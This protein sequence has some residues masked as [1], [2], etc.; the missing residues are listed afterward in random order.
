MARSKSRSG[1]IDF[2]QKNHYSSVFSRTLSA[3]KLCRGGDLVSQIDSNALKSADKKSSKN[4]S[5]RDM[6]MEKRKGELEEELH[7]TREKLGVVEVERD[8]AI[9]EL[10]EAKEEAHEASIRGSEARKVKELTM[11]LKSL[12][13]ILTNSQEELKVKDD[14]IKQFELTLVE[15]D[16]SL[17]QLKEELR[18]VR[19]SNKQATELLSEGEKK[20][21][22]LEAQVDRGKQS[23]SKIIDSLEIKSKQLEQKKIELEE[24]KLEITSLHEKIELLQD[25][26]KQNSRD[27]KG[28]S[29]KDNGDFSEEDNEWLKS[30]LQLT[31]ENL[32]RA[33]E[34]E[35]KASLKVK[36]LLDEMELFKN[37]LTM[38]IDAEEKSA[39]AM[40]DLALALKEVTTEANQTKEKLDNAQLELEQVKGEVE[41]LKAM[42]RSTDERHQKLLDEAKQEAELYKN[43]ADRLRLEAEDSIL[44]SNGKEMGFVSCIKRA[45][46]EAA[47]AQRESARLAESLKTA[48]DMTR[49]AREETN[50]L[51]DILKQAINEANAA[52]A[53]ADIA[54]DENSQLKD[55]LSERDDSLNFISQ[56]HESLGTNLKIEDKEK[57]GTLKSS[58]SLEDNNSKKHFSFNLQDLKFT[59]E[60]EKSDE[61]LLDEDPKKAETLKGSIFDSSAETPRSEL[62]TPKSSVSTHRR[63][64]SSAFTDDT[65]TPNSVDFDHLDN[66]QDG[67]DRERNIHR[68]RKTMFWRV[69]DLLMIGRS[70]HKKE[71]STES[72]PATPP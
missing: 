65:G 43:T 59:N 37:E 1:S 30:E 17:D 61:K 2:G 51:R 31:K 9:D 64:Y 15:R 21:Q 12:K 45:E 60:Y 35:K 3:S 36:S 53:A 33:Q 22:E 57:N 28:L 32:A 48:E 10:K 47:V 23:E 52:K 6:S 16:A 70:F 34:D 71:P 40:E 8:Q 4:R 19:E 62:H 50:K 24:S 56:E 54:R 20:I 63:G 44:A 39:K 18:S 26:S 42:V 38:A 67:S 5:N 68:R 7:R 25:S 27:L 41:K 49:A 29:N 72:T 46:E 55:C 11:E 69:G 66:I 13:E 14:K 58:N